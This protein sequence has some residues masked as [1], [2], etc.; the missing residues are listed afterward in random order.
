[1]SNDVTLR[2]VSVA[3]EQLLTAW[4]TDPEFTQWWDGPHTREKIEQTVLNGSDDG[5]EIVQPYVVVVDAQRVGFAQTYYDRRQR[6]GGID[7]VL[8]PSRIGRGIGPVAVRLLARQLYDGGA[9]DVVVDPATANRRS[10]RAFRKAGFV[11]LRR[12]LQAG[13][14]HVIMRVPR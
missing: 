9:V 14:E 11:E 4:F 5:V 3:D 13:D 12:E 10:V 7:I 8:H 2:E 1:M 6:K